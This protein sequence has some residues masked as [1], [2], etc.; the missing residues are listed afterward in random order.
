MFCYVYYCKECTPHR[1]FEENRQMHERNFPAT[2]PECGNRE[3]KKIPARTQ[4]NMIFPGST[5][6]EALA[7]E[8]TR[9]SVEAQ[10]E[11]FRS[12]DELDTA[13]GM[14]KERAI[15]MGQPDKQLIGSVPS[16]FQGERY[17]PSIDEV[18][19]ADKLV[20]ERVEASVVGDDKKLGVVAEA[21]KEH[22]DFVKG[23]A[24]EVKQEF[25]PKNTK[26]DHASQ[27]K[28]SQSHRGSALS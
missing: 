13:I 10:K 5:K 11:G 20:K 27:I 22:E 9:M 12:K 7:D 3:C 8:L 19:E 28:D 17:T 25:V 24:A 1:E 23:K 14:A 4:F 15:Q 21:I 26:E 16:P 6:R 2:C 18:K